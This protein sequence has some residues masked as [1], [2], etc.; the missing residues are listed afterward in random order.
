ME[1]ETV[2][3]RHYED[4]LA[5]LEKISFESV[6]PNLGGT[7]EADGINIS[8]VSHPSKGGKPDNVWV[9]ASK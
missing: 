3:K 5:Q 8:Q 6:A 1:K 4:Y 7:A 2:F 9:N